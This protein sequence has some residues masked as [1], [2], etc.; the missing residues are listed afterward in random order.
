MG[1]P[2]LVWTRQWICGHFRRAEH[3]LSFLYPGPP[4]KFPGCKVLHMMPSI[5]EQAPCLTNTHG[6]KDTKWRGIF[7][8]VPGS[9][10]LKNYIQVWRNRKGREYRISE[11]TG[12]K[13][14]VP[15]TSLNFIMKSW[16]KQKMIWIYLLFI[17]N[18]IYWGDIVNKII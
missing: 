3:L 14:H 8:K 5:R 15:Q 1:R 18:W 9:L 10:Q 6:H 12:Q 4:G 16:K 2:K 13:R 7:I 17:F 11:G